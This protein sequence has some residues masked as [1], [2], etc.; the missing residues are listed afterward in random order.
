MKNFKILFILLC[1]NVCLVTGCDSYLDIIPDNIITVD[2]AF[3]SESNANKFRETC[4][5]YLPS[6][7]RPFHDPNWIAGRG[8]EFWYYNGF[9]AAYPD[10]GWGDTPHGLAIM[11]GGQNTNDPYLNYW[12]GAVAGIP[13]FRAIRECNMFLEN[14]EEKNI[15]PDI[16]EENRIWWP[17]EVKFLK[18]YYHFYLMH[19]YGPIPIIRRNPEMNASP[20]E[21]RVFREPIDD[22]VNYIVEV[23]DDAI[24]SL[25]E[26]DSDQKMSTRSYEQGGRITSSIA[27]A[28]KARVLVWAASRLFNGNE[29]YANFKDSRG[30][31]LI[32]SGAPD[33]GKWVR[34]MNACEEAIKHIEGKNFHVLHTQYRQEHYDVSPATARKYILR[35]A[36]TNAFDPEIIWPSTHPTS[37]FGGWG[38]GTQNLWQMN[39]ERECMPAFEAILGATNY[40]SHNGSMGTTLKMAEQFYTNNGLP[41]DEDEEWQRRIGGL[42]LRYDTR[43]ASGDEYHRYYIQGGMTTAQLN[44]YREPRFYAYVGFD[45]GIWEGAGRPEAESYVVNR[46]TLRQHAQVPTGYFIK[47]VVHPMSQFDPAG[48]GF[49]YN[50]RPYT[51][52]YMRLSDLYLLYAEAINEAE[53]I[54]GNHN[55]DMFKYIDMVR[56]RAGLEGVRETWS[57]SM[58]RNPTKPNTQEGMRDIIRRERA[59]ELCFEGIRTEDMRRWR[60]AHTEFNQPIRGWNGIS[61]YNGLGQGDLTDNVYYRV[62]EHYTL[63]GGYGVKDYLWPIK[64]DNL[65]INGNLVQNPGW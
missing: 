32:P 45:G 16:S 24:V 17:G 54:N 47:K 29:F 49:N 53:G 23:L 38:T 7:L 64:S 41:I 25:D 56:R 57:Q 22:V 62:T 37:G 12:D 44:F 50:S 61:E 2:D 39:L 34:A 35:Y 4:Y 19:L 30:V 14:V 11:Q 5:G 21:L 40:G 52:P 59:V 51:F 28:V 36:V 6:T 42:E 8:D 63:R 3:S 1:L 27:R 46:R 33:V 55:G 60:I 31:Q 9:T 13:L 26:I 20:E 10:L 18:A 58:S 48:N 15:I 43:V 65:N